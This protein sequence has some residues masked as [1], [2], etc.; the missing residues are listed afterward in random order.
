M[1]VVMLKSR[2]RQVVATLS[3][4]PCKYLAQDAHARSVV[5][6]VQRTRTKA[7]VDTVHNNIVSDLATQLPGP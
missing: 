3:W 6:A 5:G 1:V 7:R 2:V 4:R